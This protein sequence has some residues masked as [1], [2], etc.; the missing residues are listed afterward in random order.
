MEAK[1]ALTFLEGG[2]IVFEATL[3]SGDEHP[4]L[5]AASVIPA[6]EGGEPWRSTS[7]A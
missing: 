5:V 1:L 6:D 7:E 2:P 4:E 3:E